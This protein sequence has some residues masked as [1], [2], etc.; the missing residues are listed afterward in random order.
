[1]ALRLAQLCTFPNQNKQSI[2]TLIEIPLETQLG[3]ERKGGL[4]VL[5]RPPNESLPTFI[6]KGGWHVQ[7]LASSD[8][9]PK[10]VNLPNA[11]RRR[12]GGNRTPV[13]KVNSYPAT[14]IPKILRV[15][16]TPG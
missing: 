9:V 4:R 2:F 15:T 8:F 14:T 1:M 16:L 5:L 6:W 13:Q 11:T 3:F 10:L 12:A 7:I